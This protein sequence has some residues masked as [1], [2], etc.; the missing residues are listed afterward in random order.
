MRRRYGDADKANKEFARRQFLLG[1]LEKFVSKG[2]RVQ[3][4]DLFADVSW[5][6]SAREPINV[7]RMLQKREVLSLMQTI[8][9]LGAVVPDSI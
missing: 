9:A 5:S 4:M 7:K 1:L 3:Q 8:V 6:Y 2:A